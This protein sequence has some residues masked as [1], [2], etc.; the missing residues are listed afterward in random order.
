MLLNCVSCCPTCFVTVWKIH[1]CFITRIFKCYMNFVAGINLNLYVLSIACS[2]YCKKSNLQS[3]KCLSSCIS[4]NNSVT[5]TSEVWWPCNWKTFCIRRCL[6]CW[7]QVAHTPDTTGN[8]RT[9]AIVLWYS[10]FLEMLH[11]GNQLL[12]QVSLCLCTHNVTCFT[13]PRVWFVSFFF[14]QNS[15]Y[16]WHSVIYNR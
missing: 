5:D 16:L 13:P 4:S 10:P 3:C 8:G 7:A 14:L 12:H 1:N 15:Y 9:Y 6:S 11:A 2:K